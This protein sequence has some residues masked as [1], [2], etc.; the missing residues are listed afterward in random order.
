[1]KKQLIS[2]MILWNSYTCDKFS[3][4]VFHI[5]SKL[6][7]SIILKYI[8]VM[9]VLILLSKELRGKAECYSRNSL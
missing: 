4:Q 2:F 3:F 7:R 5:T 9:W 1:M 6:D 8:H